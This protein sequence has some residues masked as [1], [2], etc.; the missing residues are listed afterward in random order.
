M[1]D[2]DAVRIDPQAAYRDAYERSM[3]AI[4]QLHAIVESATSSK[5]ISDRATVLAALHRVQSTHLE[6][7]KAAT[8]F[9]DLD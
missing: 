4:C 3:D 9:L 2:R 5:K 1:Q 7:V 6:W 8:P